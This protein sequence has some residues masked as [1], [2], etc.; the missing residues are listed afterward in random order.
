MKC[1]VIDDEPLAIQVLEGYINNT[2]DLQLI[3]TFDDAIAGA[4]YLTI[5]KPDLLFIDIDMPD[6]SGLEIVASLENKPLIVFTTAHKK[7]AIDGFELEA[8]DFL[9]KPIA[10]ERFLK[11]VEKA[12]FH[13][14]RQHTVD[15]ESIIVKSEYKKVKIMLADIEYIEGMEDYIKIYVSG[16]GHPVLTLMS[17]KRILEMLPSV[18]FSRIHRSYIV[19]HKKVMAIQNKKA[20][21]ENGTELNIGES[22]LDF[23]RVWESAK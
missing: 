7:Y 18:S 12:R 21:L 13:L 3:R 11:A 10:Y 17:L 19:P 23:I 6:I 1:V 14:D 20:I 8:V 16:A 22:H 2:K 15:N 4:G 5:E 9:L